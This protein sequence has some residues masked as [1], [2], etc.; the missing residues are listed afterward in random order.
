MDDLNFPNEEMTM[1]KASIRALNE[2]AKAIQELSE[3]ELESVRALQ[4]GPPAM[5]VGCTD[6]GEALR[7]WQ[8]PSRLNRTPPCAASRRG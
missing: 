4:E 8:P 7:G 2:K 5:P 1:K 3:G 6:S